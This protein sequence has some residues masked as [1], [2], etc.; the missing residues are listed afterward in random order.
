M[1]KQVIEKISESPLT[2]SEVKK[3]KEILK[4]RKEFAI[5]DVHKIANLL[6]PQFKG[7]DLTPD[8]ESFATEKIYNAAAK[9]PDVDEGQVLEELAN[10]IAKQGF[11]F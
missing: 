11:F 1:E 5:Y 4:N 7:C 9:I 6:D 2:A 8:D 10:Y 3:V